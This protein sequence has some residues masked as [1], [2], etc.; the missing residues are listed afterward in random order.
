MKYQIKPFNLL[1]KY[2]QNINQK[3][4]KFKALDDLVAKTKNL[5]INCFEVLQ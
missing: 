1:F 3:C 5:F 4:N 2:L